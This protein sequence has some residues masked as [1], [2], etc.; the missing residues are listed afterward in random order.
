MPIYEYQCQTCGHTLEALQKMADA[1][2]TECPACHTPT[3][4]KLISAAGFHLKGSGWYA[5]DFK[6]GK[7]AAAETASTASHSC[8]GGACP[9]CSD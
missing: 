7:A 3:L 2:L 4:K 6:G 8:G 5:S 9:R 1:P